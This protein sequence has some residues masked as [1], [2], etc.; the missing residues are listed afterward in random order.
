MIDRGEEKERVQEI[1]RQYLSTLERLN[2]LNKVSL[3]FV[4]NV[5]TAVLQI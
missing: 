4:V 1:N 2:V 3:L 5:E